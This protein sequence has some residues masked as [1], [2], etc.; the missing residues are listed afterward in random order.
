MSI[1]KKFLKSK[2]QCK[3]TFKVTKEMA[4][5]ASAVQVLGDFNDW[6]RSVEPM[7]ALKN[8]S[9]SAT[10]DLETGRAYQFRYLLDGEAWANEPEAD[11]QVVSPYG[12]SENSVLSL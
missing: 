4:A 1:T 2:P 9:F 6:D 7:K 3:V 8:G 10:L 12:D 5:G 11:N